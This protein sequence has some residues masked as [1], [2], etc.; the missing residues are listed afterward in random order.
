MSETETL[1]MLFIHQGY[2]LVFPICLAV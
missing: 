1:P 2:N